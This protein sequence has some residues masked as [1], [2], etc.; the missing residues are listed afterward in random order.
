GRLFLFQDFDVVYRNVFF[1]RRRFLGGDFDILQPQVRVAHADD[2]AVVD[3]LL[4]NLLA[5]DQRAAGAVVI[6]DNDVIALDLE[7]RV[8]AGNVEIVEHH[9]GVLLAAADGI[10]AQFGQSKD[11]ALIGPVNNS[12]LPGHELPPGKL[13]PNAGWA[14]RKGRSARLTWVKQ[15]LPR[16]G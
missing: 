8:D 5:V 4:A 9:L 12:E 1:R 7:F 6:G 14:A 10:D 11:A 15:S 3:F 16:R 13:L 2:V